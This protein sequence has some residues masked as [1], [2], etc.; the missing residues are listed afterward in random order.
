MPIITSFHLHNNIMSE[1]LF[2]IIIIIIISNSY[3]GKLK[4][5]L[6][7]VGK[8]SRDRLLTAESH[9][10]HHFAVLLPTY[11]LYVMFLRQSIPSSNWRLLTQIIHN[12]N[13]SE[14]ILSW[15]VRTRLPGRVLPQRNGALQRSGVYRVVM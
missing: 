10:F 12:Q 7:I 9:H 13:W 11:P 2:I 3:I 8:S 6:L 14:F 5:R 4:L 1:V 15:N